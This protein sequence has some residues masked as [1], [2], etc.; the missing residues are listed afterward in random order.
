MKIATP[1]RLCAALLAALALT[2]VAQADDDHKSGAAKVKAAKKSA[3][4]S[5]ASIPAQT[6]D[7]PDKD[8]PQTTLKTQKSTSRS[9]KRQGSGDD[10][11]T[12]SGVSLA[13]T[14]GAVALNHPGQLLASN[15]FQCHGTNGRGMEHLAGESAREIL[16]ELNEMRARAASRHIMNVHAQG[17]TP[18]QLGLI[19]DYFSK[20]TP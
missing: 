5:A 13:Y 12:T 19:A 2:P 14:S 10:R 3:Q 1:L 17:Y 11:A 16:D 7:S 20:Q 8:D 4:S 18:E 6:T 15:C 9:G